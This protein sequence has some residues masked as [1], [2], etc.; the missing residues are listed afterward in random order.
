MEKG[1]WVFLFLLTIEISFF[2]VCRVVWG[3]HYTD[4]EEKER[5]LH[6]WSFTSWEITGAT[7]LLLLFTIILKKT[8]NKT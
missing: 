1:F 4:K 5:L 8:K 2:G 7:I 6:L 3:I